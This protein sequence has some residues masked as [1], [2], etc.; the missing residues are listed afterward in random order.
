[1]GF[2]EG[3]ENSH[4]RFKLRKNIGDAGMSLDKVFARLLQLEAVK[5]IGEEEKEPPFFAIQSKENFQL[6]IS[7]KD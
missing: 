4:E 5:Q 7:I 3:I 6:F 2:L 1:M